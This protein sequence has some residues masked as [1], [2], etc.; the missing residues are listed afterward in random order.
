MLFSRHLNLVAV[1]NEIALLRGSQRA[2]TEPKIFQFLRSSHMPFST[3]GESMRSLAGGQRTL[4]S[5]STG[6]LPGV[7]RP[8]DLFLFKDQIRQSNSIK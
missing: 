7:G 2:S 8:T 1:E 4:Q 3:L 6:R 5:T